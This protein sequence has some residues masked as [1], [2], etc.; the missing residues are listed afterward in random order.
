MRVLVTGGAGFLGRAMVEQLRERGDEVLSFSR[1]KHPELSVLGIEHFQGDLSDPLAVDLAAK[2][3]DVVFHVAAKA[4]ISGPYREYYETNVLGTQNIISACKKN[5]VRR[6]VYTST[7]SV[8]FNGRDEK[9]IDESTPYSDRFLAWY[10][11]TKCAAEHAVLSANGPALATVALRPHLIWGPGDHHLIPRLI[12]RARQGKLMRV[13]N[14]KNMVDTIYV[15]NAAGAHLLACDRLAPGSAIA[16][17]AYF[18]SQ[19]EPVNLWDFINRILALADL[20]PVTRSIPAWLAYAAGGGME[21][22]HWLLRRHNEP[23]MTRFLARQLSTSHWLNI[24]AARQDLGYVPSV[25]TEE[26]LKRLGE[27]LKQEDM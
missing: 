4:G 17:K 10:P 20:P 12:A 14:G 16:G 15:D 24:S 25:S 13:G 7:P 6:L 18:L 11:H 3:C 1:Q 2:S 21:F 26:G 5:G 9:G 22:K 23:N 19:G 27:W 8:V